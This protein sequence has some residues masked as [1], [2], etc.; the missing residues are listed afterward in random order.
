MPNFKISELTLCDPLSGKEIFPILQK[1]INNKNILTTLAANLAQ[2]TTFVRDYIIPPGTIWTY[3]A[4]V[5]SGRT[6]PPG[7]LLCDGSAYSVN[8]YK[9]LYKAI[10]DSYGQTTSPGIIF[11][12]PDIKGRFILGFS[13]YSR[14]IAPGF[15]TYLGQGISLG[16][17]GGEFNHI[18]DE[19]T[20]PS[21]THNLTYRTIPRPHLLYPDYAPLPSAA[22]ER[23]GKVEQQQGESVGFFES[24]KNGKRDG[25]GSDRDYI[26]LG[27]I[28]STD[29]GGNQP[30]P[31]TPPYICLNHIIKY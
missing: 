5:N 11:K 31:N 2:L 14:A 23:T 3:A 1:D 15:G 28:H 19:N 20:L 16:S 22:G 4:P 10:G 13:S 18:L 24:G 8:T 26:K 7:W 25:P 21:H 12:I 9:N 6:V 29:T 30:H 27:G 17:I